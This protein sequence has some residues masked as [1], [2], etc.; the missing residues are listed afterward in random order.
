MFY[1]TFPRNYCKYVGIYYIMGKGWLART[2]DSHMEKGDGSM[3]KN[4]LLQQL[5]GGKAADFLEKMYGKDHAKEN[6]NRYLHVMEGFVQAF[7]NTDMYLFTSAG[8]TE[9]SGNHTDHNHGKVLAG[10][11]NLDCVAAA[12]ANGTDE[13][14]IISETYNQRTTFLPAK[15]WRGPSI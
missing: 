2:N 13:I 15:R 9:I 6:K 12:A 11:I 8:R 3:E 10:S 14:H 7:K 5:D 1:K 4:L